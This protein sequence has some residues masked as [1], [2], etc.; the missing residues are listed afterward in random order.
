MKTRMINTK[1]WNDGWVRKINPLDRYLFLYLLSNEH[2]N[3][4]GIY[5]L[6]LGTIA[7]ETGIDERDLEK[8]MFPKLEPK[9][10]YFQG[11]VI[12][13]NFVKHQNQKSPKIRTGIKVNLENVPEIVMKKAIR[14]GYPINTL[15]HSNSNLNPN[16]NSNIFPAAKPTGALKAKKKK[17]D[18]IQCDEDGN[19][20]TKKKTEN[21]NKLALKIQDYFILKAKEI[22]G[23][24][25][26][27]DSTGYFRVL[28][29]LN[30]GGLEKEN[31]IKMIDDWFAT[32]KPDNE[33]VQLT[34]CLSNNQI[35]DWKVKNS[36]EKTK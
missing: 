11:W 14:Y 5:E 16:L 17:M 21:K 19:E 31:V 24:K 18:Y 28:Y 8:S 32:G 25:P 10:I 12:L 30:T 27:K 22:T 36:Y 13:S 1:F 4:S 23:I 6:P 33:L 26:I 34:R 35:N 20:I 29:S 7:F 9:V 3:I 2:T 15:S